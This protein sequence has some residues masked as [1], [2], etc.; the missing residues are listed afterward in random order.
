M[1]NAQQVINKSPIE[2]IVNEFH[3]KCSQIK[4]DIDLK[5]KDLIQG[6][7]KDIIEFSTTFEEVQLEVNI[8]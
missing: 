8:K 3:S 6:T 2:K 7:I 1:S 4:L 5:L